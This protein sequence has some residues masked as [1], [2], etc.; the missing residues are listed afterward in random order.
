MQHL[1]G[2]A[3]QGPEDE[4]GGEGEDMRGGRMEVLLE[5]GQVE[6]GEEGAAEEQEEEEEDEDEEEEEEEPLGMD[7]EGEE[8]EEEAWE[9]A[10]ERGARVED[11]AVLHGSSRLPANPLSCVP[12]GIAVLLLW[13]RSRAAWLAREPWLVHGQ[14]AEYGP[15][16]CPGVHSSG[17]PPP[18]HS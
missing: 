8:E 5:H 7:L 14:C 18:C 3:V 4:G 11:L 1:D 15:L 12:C 2:I 6:Q 9:D 13:C 16:P 17:L 10:E